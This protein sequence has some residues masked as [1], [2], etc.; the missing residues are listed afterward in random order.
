MN[1][2][3]DDENVSNKNLLLNKKQNHMESRFKELK[4]TQKEN[5]FL[6]DVVNDYIKYFT[7]IKK[8][9]T[10]QYDALRKISE[11]IDTINQT[12]D[13]TERLL[14]ESINDQREILNRM[15]YIKSKIDNITNILDGE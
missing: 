11:H 3:I 9:K 7:I 1:I 13:V 12:S 15:K 2:A 5:I 6:N 10:E 8:Q 14:H 4:Q